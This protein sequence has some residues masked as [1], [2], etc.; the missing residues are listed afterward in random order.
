MA[1]EIER[2]RE[3]LK[4]GGY[5][6]RYL[7]ATGRQILPGGQL[8]CPNPSAHANGDAKPSAHL[9]ED[10]SGD[11][12]K[13]FACGGS[14]DIFSLV[15]MDKGTDFMGA[16]EFLAEFFGLSFPRRAKRRRD[17]AKAKTP[18]TPTREPGPSA[19]TATASAPATATDAAAKDTAK[20]ND[21]QTTKEAANGETARPESAQKFLDDCAAR[22][23]N[24][25]YFEKRGVSLATAKRL[26]CGYD[27]AH[28]FPSL[29]ERRR[30]VVFP[31]AG[32]WAARAVD[33]KAHSFLRGMVGGSSFNLEALEAADATSAVFIVEGQFD[34]LS[35]EEVGGHALALGGVQHVE[36]LV[37]RVRRKPPSCALIVALDREDN[38]QKAAVVRKAAERLAAEL[39][40]AGAFVADFDEPLFNAHDANDAL[41]ADREA[42]KNAVEYAVFSASEQYVRRDEP[43]D[44]ED[45]D[46]QNHDAT[47][48]PGPWAAKTISFA[49]LPEPKP[50]EENER[51]LFKR[52]YLR[53][54]HALCL[55]SCAGVGK[56]VISLQLALAWSLGKP[57]LGLEPVR[58]LRIAVFTFEDDA[59]DNASFR[60]DYRAGFR[61]E[62]WSDAEIDAALAAVEF[63]ELGG[64][65]DEAFAEALAEIQREKQR[66]LYIVNPLGDI[67]DEYDISDNAEAKHFFKKILDPVIKGE[68]DPFTSCAL[69]L[70]SHTG[71]APKNSSDRSN[72]LRGIFA[73]YDAA[74]SAALMNWTRAS[75][76]IAPTSEAGNFVL[77][78]AKRQARLGWRDADGKPT[79][80]R[81]IS[82]SP[83]IKFWIPTPEADVRRLTADGSGKSR[84]AVDPAQDAATLAATLRSLTSGISSVEARQ[85]AQD[86]FGQKRGNAAFAK[87]AQTPRAFNVAV[88]K[89]GRTVYYG[90]MGLGLGVD[91]KNA[92]PEVE[93]LDD[94]FEADI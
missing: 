18:A 76:L 39:R 75:L 64:R 38:A 44:G 88:T 25:K 83:D 48:R 3:E 47:S 30:A 11:R 34:A 9:Y 91:E 49:A 77:L 28:Y 59:E 58:P 54:G 21:T 51:A 74:G 22:I 56:S 90:G 61:R 4:R 78:G 17:A 10:A 72:F 32:G 81:Y 86:M 55:V 35:I 2:L 46:A 29:H 52:G 7:E 57:C 43:C 85:R 66:D 63:I 45:A 40:E 13:C 94:D 73:Q 6:R 26:G 36:E 27:P 68:R 8:R 41:L 84:P 87:I 14:W 15:E 60:R 65:T 23:G 89:N 33:V 19:N 50:E 70:V 79:N 5:L 82:Y 1:T 62:G 93:G 71:K 67:M 24:A 31:A 12:V 37:E 42:F 69:V 53:K 20:E 80:E 92:P 16:L